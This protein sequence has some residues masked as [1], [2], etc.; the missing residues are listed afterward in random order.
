MLIHLT[1]R[2][3]NTIYTNNTTGSTLAQ[4]LAL[5]YVQLRLPSACWDRAEHGPPLVV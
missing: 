3:Q 4:Q 1:K 5:N 2:L